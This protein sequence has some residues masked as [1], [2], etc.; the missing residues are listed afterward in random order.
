MKKITLSVA[1][2]SLAISGFCTN[3]PTNSELVKE[4]SITTEDMIQSL[5]MTNDTV[6][7]CYSFVQMSEIYVHNLLDILRKLEDLQM[8]LCRD[9]ECP[10]YREQIYKQTEVER[11]R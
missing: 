7:Q 4:M 5:R 2:L 1:A 11:R 9:F 8:N 3:P 10:N 6:T